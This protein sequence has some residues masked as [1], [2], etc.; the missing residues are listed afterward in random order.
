M[1]I[2]SPAK[3]E[4]GRAVGRGLGSDWLV[5]RQEFVGQR[6]LPDPVAS[7]RGAP[8]LPTLQS[9]VASGALAAWTVPDHVGRLG[10]ALVLPDWLFC[11]GK[12][13]LLCHSLS[14]SVAW[15][16]GG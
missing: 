2:A 9:V 6:P 12:A 1:G 4:A 13:G 5:C 15:R 16:L 7:S 3:S 8:E 14:A 10:L 11:D